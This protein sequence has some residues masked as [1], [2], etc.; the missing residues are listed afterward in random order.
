MLLGCDPGICVIVGG[1]P[2]PPTIGCM[3]KYVTVSLFFPTPFG[4]THHILT[5]ERPI[6]LVV[7]YLCLRVRGDRYDCVTACAQMNGARLAGRVRTSTASN[8]I[9]VDSTRLKSART[10][11]CEILTKFL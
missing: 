2:V 6:V 7:L 11:E 3:R 4:L 1:G 5:H 10:S 9:R 8:C